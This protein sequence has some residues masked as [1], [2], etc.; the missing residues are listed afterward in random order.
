MSDHRDLWHLRHW[1]H[2]RQ[3]RTWIHDNFCY[4]TINCDTGQHSQ[5]LQ[6]FAIFWHFVWTERDYLCWPTR[7]PWWVGHVPAGNSPFRLRFLGFSKNIT[8]KSLFCITL[9]NQVWGLIMSVIIDYLVTDF[10]PDKIYEN[11]HNDGEWC[12]R[13]PQDLR[14]SF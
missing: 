6:C 11:S 2:Y 7:A 5:F 8:T 10:R 13:T 14:R 12:K 3:L 9:L 1:L 4:L